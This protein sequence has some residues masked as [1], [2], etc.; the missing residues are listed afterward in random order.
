MNAEFLVLGGWFSLLLAAGCGVWMAIVAVRMIRLP[1]RN[2]WQ[3]A[4]L[5]F[6]GIL[7]AY[8]GSITVYA[9]FGMLFAEGEAAG[10]AG[11]GFVLYLF[12]WIVPIVVAYLIGLAAALAARVLHRRGISK[13]KRTTMAVAVLAVTIAVSLILILPTWDTPILRAARHSARDG[14]SILPVRLLL[15]LG[16]DVNAELIGDGTTPLLYAVQRDNGNRELAE[17]LIASGADVNQRDWHGM[18]PIFS[19]M[20]HTDSEMLSLLIEHGVNVNE[21]RRSDWT[22]LHEA[23]RLGSVEKA[24][25]LIQAGAEVAARDSSGRTPR[26]IALS[27]GHPEAAE[28][29]Y[30]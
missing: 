20:D 2:R 21:R 4:W 1:E 6:A 27:S 12:L 10:W 5:I 7:T 28:L 18:S 26:D 15:W 23:A 25:L 11:L 9:F 17:L 14:G 8:C 22:P 19:V 16:A 30:E 3:S 29:L 13:R 24:T